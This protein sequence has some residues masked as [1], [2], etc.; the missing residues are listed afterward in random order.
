MAENLILVQNEVEASL[1]E[2]LLT[3]EG[4]PHY[5]KSYRD[6]AYGGIWKRNVAWGQVECPAEQRER[7]RAI[8]EGLRKRS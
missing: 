2:A 8:L 4:I 6:L 7:V 1:L 3:E 5:I